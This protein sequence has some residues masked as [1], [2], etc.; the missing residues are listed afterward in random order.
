[1]KTFLSSCFI[2]CMLLCS[3][4]AMGQRV[5][6]KA[7]AKLKPSEDFD[8]I[9]VRPMH[10]DAK[11]SSFVIWIKEKVRL[12]KHEVHSEH[13]YVLKGKGEMVLGDR[14][15]EVKKGDLIFIPEGTPHAV[16]VT[17]G[18]L[19]VISIQSPEFKGKDRVFLD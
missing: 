2:A 19:K 11:S 12:H 18:T 5:P 3:F 10:S 16:R 17:G 9:H 14:T 13:V 1:M 6:V 15:F 4:S 7:A 8:N